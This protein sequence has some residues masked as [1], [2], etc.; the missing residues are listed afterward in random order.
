M[1]KSKEQKA[2]LERLRQMRNSYLDKAREC[3]V[4]GDAK[5]Y[6]FWITSANEIS[7][8]I[9]AINV[10][11]GTKTVRRIEKGNLIVSYRKKIITE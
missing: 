3:V 2:R 10:P 4:Y 7:N 5:G 11:G 8:Q 6:H 1:S 9:M